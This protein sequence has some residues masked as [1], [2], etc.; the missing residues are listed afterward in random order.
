MYSEKLFVSSESLKQYLSVRQ[1]GSE[2]AMLYVPRPLSQDEL[3][4]L[5]LTDG[6]PWFDEDD[7]LNEPSG[8]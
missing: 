6:L 4:Y 3:T 5:L 1:E 8:V 2:V 7:L